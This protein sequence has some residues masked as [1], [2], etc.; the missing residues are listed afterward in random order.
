MKKVLRR[1]VLQG[2]L[3]LERCSAGQNLTSEE[4]T[5]THENQAEN[6]IMFVV[7]HFQLMKHNSVRRQ[8][9]YIQKN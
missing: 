8:K 4:E 7:P 3:L 6:S 9:K 2:I 1:G 5:Q